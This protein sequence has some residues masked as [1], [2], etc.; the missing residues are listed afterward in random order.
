M[1]Y[2]SWSGDMFEEADAVVL[3]VEALERA[4]LMFRVAMRYSYM[5]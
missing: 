1:A 4:V 5:P 3:S 2:F